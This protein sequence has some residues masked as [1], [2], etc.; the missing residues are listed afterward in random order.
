M[1]TSEINNIILIF[2]RNYKNLKIDLFKNQQK[3]N[4][5]L[6]F[7]YICPGAL[8]TVKYLSKNIKNEN[9]KTLYNKI[10]RLTDAL[11][12][13]ELIVLYKKYINKDILVSM[14]KIIGNKYC[15]IAATITCHITK[16][17]ERLPKYLSQNL[18]DNFYH[19]RHKTL[20]CSND[21]NMVKD[22]INMLKKIYEGYSNTN[23]QNL[24]ICNGERDGVSGCRDCCK[25]YFSYGQGYT[26]CVNNCMNY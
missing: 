16:Y 6:N 5:F 3:K 20:I 24:N 11:F 26:T 21:N 18:P 15:K 25:K 12:F 7:G 17:F 2:E 4:N 13:L 23:N 10:R 8:K 22:R 14:N 1:N 9:I 19:L